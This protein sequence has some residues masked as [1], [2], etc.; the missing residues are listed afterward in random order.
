MRV[1]LVAI[2]LDG[3]VVNRDGDIIPGARDAVQALRDRGVA[4][5]LATGRMYQPSDRFAAELNIT[6]PL[7]CYQGALIREPN[8][9]EVL[10]H[11]PLPSPLARELV[12]ELRRAGVHRYAYIDGG[13]Y[14]EETLAEDLRYARRNGVQLRLVD[15]LV[16]CLDEPPTELACRGTPEQIDLVLAR[17]RAGYG[18]EVTV[19]KVHSSFCE[20]AHAAAGKG[21]AL[22]YLAG[23]LGV[24]Q[25]DTAAIGDSPND[26]SMLRWAGLGIVVGDAPIEVREAA[27]W[28]IDTAEGDSFCQAVARL[29]RAE[30][31]V[32]RAEF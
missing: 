16:V 15:D 32:L 11:T 29:M 26:V 25:S 20:I 13:I 18:M 24:P 2:D 6:T 8:E 7:I 27:D 23:R 21:N 28:V 5:T 19:N 4:V 1:R 12:S 3:T 9:G 22:E 14:V 10:W 30:D 31:G 17:I